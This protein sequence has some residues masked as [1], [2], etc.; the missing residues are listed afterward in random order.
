M[1]QL[2]R[3]RELG[4]IE[5][6]LPRLIGPAADTDMNG[7]GHLPTIAAAVPTCQ[8]GCRRQP[9]F[10]TTGRR[11]DARNDTV[12]LHPRWLEPLKDQ[13]HSHHMPAL[14]SFLVQDQARGKD[15]LPRDKD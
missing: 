4:W 3:L 9:A 14:N 13:F 1:F 7:L 11:R 2:R 10:A 12:R 8:S 15:S 6:A 5:A